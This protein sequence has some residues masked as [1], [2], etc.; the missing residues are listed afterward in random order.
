[1]GTGEYSLKNTETFSEY[2]VKES[3][4]CLTCYIFANP[5]H[6]FASRFYTSF[7]NFSSPAPTY[8]PLFSCFHTLLCKQDVRRIVLHISSWV[9]VH[10]RVRFL[11]NVSQQTSVTEQPN[12]PIPLPSGLPI[13]SYAIYNSKLAKCSPFVGLA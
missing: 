9:R 5:L 13:P 1:M 11:L 8:C 7:W 12:L 2:G 4:M 3:S 6:Y 10:I